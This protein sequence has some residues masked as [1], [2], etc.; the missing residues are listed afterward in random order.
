MLDAVF[1]HEHL[2]RLA[3]ILWTV[4]SD[5]LVKPTE[6]GDDLLHFSAKAWLVVVLIWVTMGYFEK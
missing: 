2:E 1:V 4:V 3:L 5:D 6:H